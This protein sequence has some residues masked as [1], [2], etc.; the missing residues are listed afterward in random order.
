MTSIPT[1]AHGFLLIELMVSMT[2][3]LF[4][5]YLMHIYLAMTLATSHDA[6]KRYEVLTLIE[7][8]I[9]DVRHNPTLLEQKKYEKNGCTITWIQQPAPFPEVG[10]LK[11][12]VSHCKFITFTASWQGAK[13]NNQTVRMTTGIVL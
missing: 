3:F 2:L 8:Y 10:F 5:I 4:F 9:A 11:S 12:E 7:S 1:Y 13:K 6:L